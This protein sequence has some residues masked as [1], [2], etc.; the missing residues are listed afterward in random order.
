MDRRL[1]LAF[2]SAAALAL[3]AAGFLFGRG[4]EPENLTLAALSGDALA[5]DD[6]VLLV[7]IRRPEE[8]QQTG[9]IDG[10]LLITYADRDSFLSALRP[11]L[12]DG[13]SLALICRTGNRTSRAT[14]QIAEA[15]DAP[16]IDVAGGMVRVLREGYSPVAPTRDMGCTVC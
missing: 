12:Q 9:V 2:G 13:Q 16:V 11:H 10:A 7:D 6:S 5:Q 8:W 14:R 1:F 15:V 4:R 3:A